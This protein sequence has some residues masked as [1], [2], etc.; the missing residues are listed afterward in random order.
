MHPLDDPRL[1]LSRAW[2]EFQT[3]SD[4]IHR[5]NE[6]DTCTIIPELNAQTGEC[7]LRTKILKS[8]P[9]DWAVVIGDIAHNLRSCLDHMVWQLALSQTATPF[10]N[11]EFP[12]FIDP[13]RYNK[14]GRVS[15]RD[16]TSTMKAFIEGL[17]PYHAGNAAQ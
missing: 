1:K 2:Q 6:T 15:I 10:N 4:D 11:A 16:L 14:R 3:L 8:P 5:F 17:Q 9:L 13:S 7:I 12:I